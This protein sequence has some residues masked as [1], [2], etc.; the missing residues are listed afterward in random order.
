MSHVLGTPLLASVHE[1][2]LHEISRFYAG[3]LAGGDREELK[4]FVHETFD[5]LR[6]TEFQNPLPVFDLITTI[7]V[8]VMKTGDEDWIA[9]VVE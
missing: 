7:G 3:V 2:A 5:I 4:H 9:A 1:G 6:K 8:E